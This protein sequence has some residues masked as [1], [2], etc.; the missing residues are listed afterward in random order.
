M[1]EYLEE[2]LY[3]ITA[4]DD[5]P[6]PT[7]LEGPPCIARGI[8]RLGRTWRQIRP[9]TQPRECCW[10]HG[11]SWQEAFGHAIET[12]KIASGQSENELRAATGEDLVP[13]TNPDPEYV[14]ELLEYRRLSGWLHEAVTSLLTTDE[15]INIGGIAEWKGDGAF[16]IGGRHRAMAMMQQGTRAIIT[17]RLELLDPETGELVLD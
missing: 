9:R 14:E 13:V 16:Y 15:P 7:E 11:G 6:Y 10:Y 17:M 4:V 5:L 3:D 1:S 12:I 8:S 2:W